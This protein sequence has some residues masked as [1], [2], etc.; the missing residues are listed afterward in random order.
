MLSPRN[1]QPL[2]QARV[3]GAV[4]DLGAVDAAR[5]GVAERRVLRRRLVH[6]HRVD[7]QVGGTD[8]RVLGVLVDEAVAAGEL[9]ALV[10]LL[11]LGIPPLVLEVHDAGG[12]AVVTVRHLAVLPHS[13]SIQHQSPSTMP[14][15]SASAGLIS[16]RGTGHSSRHQGSWR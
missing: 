1:R 13:V 8:E 12:D 4:D 6:L 10:G 5:D 16:M 11:E 14:R 9:E 2:L 3:V 7:A 15:R